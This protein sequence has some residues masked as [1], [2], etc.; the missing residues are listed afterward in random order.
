MTFTN[1][2]IILGLVC[3]FSNGFNIRRR[4]DSEK[5]IEEIRDILFTVKTTA[6][7]HKTRVKLLLDTWAPEALEN[8]SSNFGTSLSW[9][10]CRSF[11]DRRVRSFAGLTVAVIIKPIDSLN[12]FT[13]GSLANFYSFF[14]LYSVGLTKAH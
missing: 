2:I 9:I 6:K 12:E 1:K 3:G 4:H 11:L 13:A 7:N 8:V 14:I 5:K 10:S